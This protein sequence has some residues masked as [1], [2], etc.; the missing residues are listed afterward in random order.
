MMNYVKKKFLLLLVFLLL[1][2]FASSVNS[3]IT[4]TNDLINH[5]INRAYSGYTLI[6]PLGNHAFLIDMNKNIIHNWSLQSFPAKML[7]DGSIICTYD[8]ESGFHDEMDEEQYIAQQDWNGTITWQFNNW[9]EGWARQHHDFER[10]GNPVG[11]YAP[12]QNFVDKGKTLVLAR[13]YVVNKSISLW[14]LDDDVIYEVDWS[15]NLTGY[16]W[17]ANDHYKQ[18]GFTKWAKIGLFYQILP[19]LNRPILRGW[20]HINSISELGENHWY[21]DGDNRFSPRNIILNSRH[22]NFIAIIE[23]STGDIV[24]RVGPDY[25][26]NTNGAWKLDQIIGPHHAHMIPKGLPGEGNILVFDNGGIGGY[27]ILGLPC[28]YMR[29]Y[30]RVVEFN[31][32]TYEIVWEY[33]N[34]SDPMFPPDGKDARFFSPLISSAQRLPNGNTLI[35]EGN[36]GRIFEVTLQNDIVWEYEYPGQTG[37]YTHNEVYRAY[38]V[39]PEWVPGNPSCYYPWE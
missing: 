21:D 28:R 23:R 2:H 30:S 14:P 33:Y 31:P 35:C 16:E 18:M 4:K 17:Y 19:W 25:S 7:P 39:P 27:G 9:E 3:H 36:K 29:L 20:L 38:R 34:N 24:W 37:D 32:I 6:N 26:K 10:E 11:Y 5:N 15:G 12:G 8:I 22:A 1:F 13:S